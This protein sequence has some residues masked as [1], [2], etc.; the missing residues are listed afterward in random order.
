MM[1]RQYLESTDLC[2]L[3]VCPAEHHEP[4][5]LGLRLLRV[6]DTGADHVVGIGVVPELAGHDAGGVLKGHESVAVN[7]LE[8]MLVNN[9]KR[10]NLQ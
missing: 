2:K 1:H 5:C 4:P 8:S 6:D 10:E 7:C 9:E 3:P